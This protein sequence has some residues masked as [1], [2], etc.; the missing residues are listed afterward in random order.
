MVKSMCCL[1]RSSCHVFHL[2]L[3]S[4]HTI[5]PPLTHALTTNMFPRR[6][7]A[8]CILNCKTH[9]HKVAERGRES[10]RGVE[11]TFLR[12]HYMHEC[13]NAI[14]VIF[15]V[16][17]QYKD[18][19]LCNVS[20]MAICMRPARY[21]H[22]KYGRG[23][24]WKYIIPASRRACCWLAGSLYFC[25]IVMKMVNLCSISRTQSS[26]K[27]HSVSIDF[28]PTPPS[29]SLSA[30]SSIIPISFHNN[31]SC[32]PPSSTLILNRAHGQSRYA[33]LSIPP[34]SKNVR[35]VLYF[36]WRCTVQ[37][38][39]L[40]RYLSFSSL[41]QKCVMQLASLSLC[42]TGPTSLLMLTMTTMLILFLS[43]SHSRR[44]SSSSS[45]LPYFPVTFICGQSGRT[46]RPIEQITDEHSRKYSK[47]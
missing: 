46:K 5:S 35:C 2:S 9:Q 3:F 30:Q 22:T 15:Y 24:R 32:L 43:L 41:L 44:G 26:P 6:L 45:T 13:I 4:V 18:D 8:C 39:S 40:A 23:M 19:Y 17:R 20:G 47:L 28:P 16:Q 12:Y 21:V 33:H 10:L 36:S 7:I 29:L 37:L 38:C 14:I 42:S 25:V 31:M 11:C 27:C 34:S 1:S